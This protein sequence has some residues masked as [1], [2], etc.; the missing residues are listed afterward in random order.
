MKTELVGV[1]LVAILTGIYLGMVEV[2]ILI[3]IGM[4]AIAGYTPRASGKSVKK[5]EEEETILHPVVYEDAGDPPYLYPERG[6]IKV[7]PKGKERKT[8][9]QSMSESGGM[10]LKGITKGVLKLLK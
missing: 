9:A 2:A 10:M 6:S 8:T 7:Y 1:A 3:G 4:I 5:T